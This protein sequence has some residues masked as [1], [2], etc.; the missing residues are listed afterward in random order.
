MDGTVK[1]WTVADYNN[2][3]ID[4][5]PVPTQSNC[6]KYLNTKG[7]NLINQ[8]SDSMND[9]DYPCLAQTKVIQDRIWSLAASP[10]GDQVVVGSS[11]LK[12]IPALHMV[13]MVTNEVIPMGQGLKRG[14]GTLD[15]TWYNEQS[16]LSCGHD[17]SARLWDTRIGTCV[18]QW[19]E[20]FDEA[21]YCMTT[22]RR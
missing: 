4:P 19:E 2:K 14:A 13:D 17:T 16:F 9:Y 15:L 3:N 12:D 7:N 10:L 5:N 1:F 18:K 21:V 6:N 8:S 20:P 11:G 22:D